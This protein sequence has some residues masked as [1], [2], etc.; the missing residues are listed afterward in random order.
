MILGV[1]CNKLILS[2][3]TPVGSSLAWRANARGGRPGGSEGSNAYAYINRFIHEVLQR[4][5]QE[6][7]FSQQMMIIFIKEN[8]SA[9]QFF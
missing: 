2:C 9:E 4:W 1:P 5:R 3:S 7:K 8:C 6:K